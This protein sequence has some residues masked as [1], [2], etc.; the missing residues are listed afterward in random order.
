MGWSERA[1]STSCT[2]ST[3]LLVLKNAHVRYC[4]FTASRPERNGSEGRLRGR[5]GGDPHRDRPRRFRRREGR[6]PLRYGYFQPDH[7]T[8]IS[9]TMLAPSTP[10]ALATTMP[11]KTLAIEAITDALPLR[12]RWARV[13]PRRAAR[14]MNLSEMVRVAE[15]EVRAAPIK[16]VFSR[17]TACF[18]H[19]KPFVSPAR[20]AEG[21]TRT[22]TRF[23]H[24]ILSAS[25]RLGPSLPDTS[26]A[27]TLARPAGVP[28]ATPARPMGHADVVGGPPAA[29][30]AAGEAASSGRTA[31][32]RSTQDARAV[33]ASTIDP[34]ASAG[35][36][37]VACRT[38]RRGVGSAQACD[39]RDG[40]TPSRSC[41]R[42]P[43]SA[44]SAADGHDRAVGLSTR[45]QSA[46]WCRRAPARVPTP[47][48]ARSPS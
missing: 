6:R 14:G 42:P 11:P 16:A 44:P 35:G 29:P 21:G 26:P 17:E 30:V 28:I 4:R 34:S 45:S 7:N 18:G 3:A 24:R 31:A 2:I 47:G 37:S 22:H 8:L 19:R 20:H 27:P 38:K 48:V 32:L 5:C 10:S 12:S 40:S 33:L 43:S 25:V 15:H 39:A 36:R 13:I 23:P 1:A 41:V 46:L 9:L